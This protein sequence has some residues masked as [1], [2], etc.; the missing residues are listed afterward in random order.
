M[1][2]SGNKLGDENINYFDKLNCKKLKKIY[3][4]ANRFTDYTIFKILNKNFKNLEFL[5][6]GFNRF[7]K[8]NLGKFKLINL[9]KLFIQSNGIS[10]LDILQHM[11]LFKI[12][13]IYLINNELN[14]IDLNSFIEFDNLE[15]VYLDNST[16]KTKNFKKIKDLKKFKYFDCNSIALNLEAINKKETKL[17]KDLEIKLNE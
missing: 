7:H 6:I 1:N 12:K 2:L 8:N 11:N 10:N 16:P 13:E 5:Y 15:R 14:E 17:I 4:Y 3:L 9:E